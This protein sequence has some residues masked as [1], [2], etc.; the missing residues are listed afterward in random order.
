MPARTPMPLNLR[1]KW[2]FQLQQFSAR[3]SLLKQA[4]GRLGPVL[5]SHHDTNGEKNSTECSE[6]FWSLTR[7]KGMTMYIHREICNRIPS[8]KPD[9]MGFSP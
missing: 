8:T 5:S 9:G 4:A 6:V 1:V 7:K 3:H 2:V